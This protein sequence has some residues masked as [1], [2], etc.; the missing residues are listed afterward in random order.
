MRGLV[1]WDAFFVNTFLSVHFYLIFPVPSN[2]ILIFALL[3][4]CLH[5]GHMNTILFPSQP[6]SCPVVANESAVCRDLVVTEGINYIA[7]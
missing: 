3:A 5:G 6:C 1:F 7:T 4:W 2:F